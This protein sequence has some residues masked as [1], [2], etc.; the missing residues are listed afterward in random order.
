LTSSKKTTGQIIS[1]DCAEFYITINSHEIISETSVYTQSLA[2]VLT[3]QNKQ[4][5]IRQKHKT[6]TT[7]D[8][9]KRSVQTVTQYN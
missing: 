1:A 4:E 2:P 7:L 6:K 8:L 5:K 9:G 3:T